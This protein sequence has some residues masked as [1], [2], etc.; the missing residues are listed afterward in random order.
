MRTNFLLFAMLCLSLN[1]LIAGDVINLG[2]SDK[3]SDALGGYTGSGTDVTIVVPAGYTSPQGTTATDL[4]TV[5]WITSATKL[6][7]KGDGSKPEIL[8]SQFKLPLAM[9]KFE[10][11]DLKVKGPNTTITSNYIIN[12]STGVTCL[13]DSFV[14]KNSEF[15]N[16]RSVAR[17]Q[18]STDGF[19]QRIKDIVIEQSVF[20]NFPDYGVIY[21]N[22]TLAYMD[23]IVISKS[24]FYGLADYVLNIPNNIQQVDVSDCTFDNVCLNAASKRYLVNLGT[25]TTPLTF[26]NCII[27]RTAANAGTFTTAGTINII[28]TYKTSDCPAADAVGTAGVTGAITAYAGATSVLFK[29]PTVTANAVTA[30]QTSTVGDYTIIDNAFEGKSSAGDP[31]WYP[32]GSGFSSIRMQVMMNQ[33]PVAD[34]ISLDR[35]YSSISIW[36]VTGQKIKSAANT[37]YLMVD[38]IQTGMYILRV[39]DAGGRIITQSFLKK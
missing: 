24:T 4:S 12:M 6:T 9:S 15:S 22:K 27:G 28:N 21:N 3:I 7:I 2:V 17:F 31:R 36:N 32:T 25:Q 34:R 10:I 37:D 39:A 29:T 13:L 18:N 23:K 1:V 8:L 11:R 14:V 35:I 38:E 30:T 19:S 33:N 16:F 26:K 5:L 20:Y